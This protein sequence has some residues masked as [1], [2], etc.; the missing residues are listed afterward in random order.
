MV[1]TVSKVISIGDSP[2]A[3]FVWSPEL[4]QAYETVTFNASASRPNGGTIV[5]YVWDFGDGHRAT[6]SNWIITYYYANAGNYVVTLNITNSAGF[7]KTKSRTI[8]VLPPQNPQADFTWSPYS[9]YVNE[10]V[11]FNASNSTPNGGVILSY[12]WNFGDG[13]VTTTSGAIICHIYKLN[14]NCT[15]S[16]KVTDS[17]GLSSTKS[18]T[19][20]ISPQCGPTANF[21]WSPSLPRPKKLVTFDASN[22]IPGWDGTHHPPIVS[23]VWAFGDGNVTTTANPVIYHTYTQEGNYTVTLAVVDSNGSVGSLMKMVR[24]SAKLLGDVNG[25]GIVNMVDIYQL[26]LRFMC[27]RGD[28]GYVA[29]CDINNDG[30]I[31]MQDIYIAILHF[32]EQ[33]KGKL[34]ALTSVKSLIKGY[35]LFEVSVQFPFLS[36][37]SLSWFLWVALVSLLFSCLTALSR[38]L[39]RYRELFCAFSR[40]HFWG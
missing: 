2:Y 9:P 18:Q 21:T 15:V 8:T 22:S 25:D 11:L 36:S 17:Q 13:N 33:I 6:S 7:W 12:I 38:L 37:L 29:D 26:I 20:K 5:S 27:K 24:V 34:L 14:G 39:S 1:N 30:I 19:V 10:A 40:P 23:Y 16:L 3:D 31:N 32:M 28:P 35:S 4:S